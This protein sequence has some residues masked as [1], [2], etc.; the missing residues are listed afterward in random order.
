MALGTAESFTRSMRA[1][2]S[3]IRR[4][5]T[6][7]PAGSSRGTG[8]KWLSHRRGAPG[9]RTFMGIDTRNRDGG[10]SPWSSR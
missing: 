1:F 10:E 2:T 5:R 6:P 7:G 4:A 3:R 8:A 9:A